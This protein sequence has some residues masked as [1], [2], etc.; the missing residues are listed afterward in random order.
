[1]YWSIFS[2]VRWGKKPKS[3]G[4]YPSRPQ[5]RCGQSRIDSPSS[6]GRAGAGLE[7]ARQ[8]A[9][10]R[11]LAGAVRAQQPK[12]TV[13]HLQINPRQCRHRTGINLDQIAYDQHGF[14]LES[15]RRGSRNHLADD[16][17]PSS[18]GTTNP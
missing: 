18:S 11:R 17:I 13:G 6:A 1:M 10:Q 2:P 5:M 3:C 9:H 16:C 4:K 14:P 7:Q 12:H 8:D 15:T